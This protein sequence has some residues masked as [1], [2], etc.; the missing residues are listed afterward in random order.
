MVAQP[1]EVN[2]PNGVG[3]QVYERRK[4]R[5]EREREKTVRE[6]EGI[7]TENDKWQMGSGE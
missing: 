6:G 1:A 7:L 5:G 4:K 2:G 3:I